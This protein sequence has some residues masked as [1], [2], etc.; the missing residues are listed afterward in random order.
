[1]TRLFS[2]WF[3]YFVWV[4]ANIFIFYESGNLLRFL[5][6]IGKIPFLKWELLIEHS[7]VIFL[8]HSTELIHYDITEFIVLIIIPLII[9]KFLK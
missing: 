4:G 1:M 5:G 2:F 7:D 3:Y 6:L 9:R 8:I